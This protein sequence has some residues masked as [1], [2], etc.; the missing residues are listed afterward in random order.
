MRSPLSGDAP[1][2]NSGDPDAP[3]V[4]DIEGAANAIARF[5]P[6][7]RVK[8]GDELDIAVAVERLHVFDQKTHDAIWG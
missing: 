7:S 5:S 6:R 4:S 8:I 1:P 3:E 2:L